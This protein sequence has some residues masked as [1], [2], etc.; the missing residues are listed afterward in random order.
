MLPLDKGY[1]NGEQIVMDGG[2]QLKGA[3]EFSHLVDLLT[4]EQWQMI[5]PKRK[6]R[7]RHKVPGR[8]P[9]RN[10]ILSRP[11]CPF[12]ANFRLANHSPRNS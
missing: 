11:R 12:M 5:K 4:E 1:V 9:N 7:P 2:E 10:P 8:H 6:D 3:S